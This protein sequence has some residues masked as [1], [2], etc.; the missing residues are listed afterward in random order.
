[1][2]MVEGGADQETV[3]RAIQNY[4]AINNDKSMAAYE[5]GVAERNMIRALDLTDDQKMELY[6]GM[7]GADSRTEKFRAMMDAGLS[8]D[9]VMDAYDK[10]AELDADAEA[11]ASEKATS[12]A[13]W[14]DTQGF[15]SDQ[16]TTIKEQLKFFS[17]I[18]TEASRYE[19]LTGAGLDAAAAKD[20][21]DAM[22][23]LSPEDGKA[24]VSDMQRLRTISG[25]SLSEREKVAAIGT[26]IGTEMETESGGKS[27]YALLNEALERGY[28]LDEWLDMK[29]AGLMTESTFKKVSV[30]ADFGVNTDLYIRC[31]EAVEALDDNGSVS[32]SEATEAISAML[33]LSSDQK[34]VLWQLQNKSWKSKNNPFSP[35]IGEQVRTAMEDEAK[36]LSLPTLG[37]GIPESQAAGDDLPGLSLPTLGG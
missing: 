11:K 31:R 26:V 36:G 4:R 15:T 19:T 13:R 30:G 25:S 24:S 10:Y 37:G 29:D 1:M 12:L 3:Y 20:L 16:A 8:W 5:R 28:T 7:T 34:A 21:T 18:P 32:Q 9:E 33:G 6:H 2:P 14:A 22:A 23:K 35:L 27:Q 17:I